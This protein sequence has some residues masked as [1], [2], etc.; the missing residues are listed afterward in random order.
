LDIATVRGGTEL[1]G[2][3]AVSDERSHLR[4]FRRQTRNSEIPLFTAVED[5]DLDASDPV[6][7]HHHLATPAT[8]R[9]SAILA[10][11][12]AAIAPAFCK[13]ATCACT[14][15]KSSTEAFSLQDMRASGPGLRAP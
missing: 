5:P 15:K 6:I 12:I 2:F 13:P 1:L 7:R 14:A 9:M 10:P 3:L 11:T 8:K 4:G